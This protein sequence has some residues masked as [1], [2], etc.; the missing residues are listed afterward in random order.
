MAR[1][2]YST[3]FKKHLK[4]IKRLEREIVDFFNVSIFDDR[5]ILSAA[6]KL[7][8]HFNVAKYRLWEFPFTY[9]INVDNF[10]KF[11]RIFGATNRREASLYFLIRDRIFEKKYKEYMKRGFGNVKS[12][13]LAKEFT[14]SVIVYHIKMLQDREVLSEQEASLALYKDELKKIYAKKLNQVW[15]QLGYK[16][17]DPQEARLSAFKQVLESKATD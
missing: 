16:I 6:N 11:E 7:N 1:R 8:L 15:E 10:T 12:L 9:R 14:D 13:I 5:S 4:K 2:G 17:Q 3:E